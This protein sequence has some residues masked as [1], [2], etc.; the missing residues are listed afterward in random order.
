[1]TMSYF[2]FEEKMQMETKAL[3]RKCLDNTANG[4]STRTAKT[5]THMLLFNGIKDL[6]Y[7]SGVTTSHSLRLGRMQLNQTV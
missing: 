1:M 2:S 3:N 6:L 4:S 5:Y 7:M